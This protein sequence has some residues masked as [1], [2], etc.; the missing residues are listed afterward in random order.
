[1]ADKPN[2]Q[3]RGYQYLVTAICFMIA[4]AIVIAVLQTFAPFFIAAGFIAA[5][6][7]IGIAIRRRRQAQQPQPSSE[8]HIYIHHVQPDDN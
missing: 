1:M 2:V 4:A 6:I 7:L 3:V 8:R 5:A